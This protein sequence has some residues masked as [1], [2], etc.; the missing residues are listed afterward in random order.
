M[1][2]TLQQQMQR[3]AGI[4]PVK[5]QPSQPETLD[6]QMARLSG[7]GGSG[8]SRIFGQ[9]SPGLI[10][11]AVTNADA[12]TSQFFG[13]TE[14]LLANVFDKFGLSDVAQHV[15][16]RSQY[17]FNR[18]DSVAAT[19][20]AAQGIGEH[21]ADFAGAAAPD[22]AAY[23][24][25]G[26][27]INGVLGPV[28]ESAG[29]L[30]R[31][32]RAFAGAAPVS[33]AL[34][35]GSDPQ[36]SAAGT[37]GRLTG[38]QTLTDLSNSA[39]GR[40][41]VG[42]GLDALGTGIGEGVATGYRALRKPGEIARPADL[43]GSVIPPRTGSITL[44]SDVP[45]IRSAPTPPPPEA[46]T[47]IHTAAEPPS[48]FSSAPARA[49]MEQQIA[50]ETDRRVNDLLLNKPAPSPEGLAALRQTVSQ[51]VRSEISR[52]SAAGSAAP[53]RRNRQGEGRILAVAVTGRDSDGRSTAAAPADRAHTTD[54]DSSADTRPG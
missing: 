41:A 48:S 27:A 47:P 54:T 45:V 31:F 39:A 16:D 40:A 9:D 18:A 43:R 30:T 3:L 12:S 15:R 32:G 14:G 17:Q 8:T 26:A 35:S 20:P 23:A 1:P 11:R 46:M 37:F 24:A 28:A 6:E 34:E 5:K 21:V 13:K 38:N 49:A 33:A 25:G 53:V 7:G 51:R 52:R 19:L 44:D 36:H 22:I 4:P 29:Y 2:E 42:V 50:D 10:A